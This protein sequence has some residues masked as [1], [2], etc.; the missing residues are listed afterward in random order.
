VAWKYPFQLIGYEERAKGINHIFKIRDISNSSSKGITA[1]FM[2]QKDLMLIAKRLKINI[3]KD[4]KK[5][6]LVQSIQTS[7][8]ETEK[9]Y[10]KSSNS[11]KIYFHIFETIPT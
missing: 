2:H 8:K 6:S 1:M 4:L 10:R 9:K 11:N 7:M 5:I 3:S